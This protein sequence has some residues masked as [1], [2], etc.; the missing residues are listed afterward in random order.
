MS[1]HIYINIY[2]YIYIYIW[3]LG[4][5]SLES[6]SHLEALTG[7]WAA[8]PTLGKRNSKPRVCVRE[9]VSV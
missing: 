3:F 4:S 9:R 8:H 2:I 5:L 7:N 1:V 6:R